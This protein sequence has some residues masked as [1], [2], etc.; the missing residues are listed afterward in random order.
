MT[1][2]L[3]KTE[4]GFGLTVMASD[5]KALVAIIDQLTIQLQGKSPHSIIVLQV[6]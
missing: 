1:I 5:C 6:A 2:L 3:K 4:P